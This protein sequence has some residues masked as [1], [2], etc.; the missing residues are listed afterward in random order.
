[1]ERFFCPASNISP[2]VLRFPPEETQHLMRVLRHRVGDLVEVTDGQGAVHTVRLR[3]LLGPE[4]EGEILETRRDLGEPPYELSLAVGVLK[5]EERFAWLVE[6]ATELGVR[7]IVPLRTRRS[8][9]Q[10][11]RP[12]R[13]KRVAIAALKQSGRS[14]LPELW[15]LTPF[16][17]WLER[18]RSRWRYIAHGPGFEFP[19]LGQLL[20][21]PLPQG[22]TLSVLIGPEGG[23]TPE[24][25]NQACAHR[26]TPCG[27]GPRRLRTET[28]ALVVASLLL[29]ASRD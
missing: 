28:A 20:P 25:F 26:V 12:E 24:E 16:E 7:R 18:D 17:R 27:L 5:Q 15:P 2:P 3:R 4:A 9:R 6:K 1:M 13:L 22:A 21:L 29:G 14:R 10:Q 11:I 23:F 19:S 8:E